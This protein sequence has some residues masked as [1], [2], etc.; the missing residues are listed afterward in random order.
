MSAKAW[1]NIPTTDTD[2][3]SVVNEDLI[4]DFHSNQEALITMP[5][6]ARWAQRDGFP[7]AWTVEVYVPQPVVTTHGTVELVL[8]FEAWVD[9]GTTAKVRAKLASGAFVETATI[10]NTTAQA[11]EIRIPDG[12]VVAAVN[13][14]AAI[15]V[16]HVLVSGGGSAHSR[17]AWGSSRWERQA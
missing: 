11:F 4:A 6:D 9:A 10:S 15:T 12:D 8:R 7:A 2:A 16:E 1:T 17:N 5:V 3:E 14:N 13:T